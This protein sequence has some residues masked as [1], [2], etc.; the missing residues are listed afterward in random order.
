MRD[1]LV[2]ID[3]QKAMGH[4]KWGPR[5]NPDAEK[6]IACLLSASQFA[7]RP[8]PAG[9]ATSATLPAGRGRS[10]AHAGAAER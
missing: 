8:M 5:N 10:P 4:P 7:C 1:A 2:L 3:Q 6:N 9:P